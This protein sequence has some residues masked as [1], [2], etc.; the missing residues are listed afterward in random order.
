MKRRI[1]LA[2][3]LAVAATLPARASG[4]VRKTVSGCVRGGIF[5]SDDGYEFKVRVSSTH[6]PMNLRPFEGQRVRM[7]GDLLP[8]DVFYPGRAPQ[9]LGPCKR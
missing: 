9:P 5:T 1:F 4:P 2:S 3:M 8:G 7:T 6:A